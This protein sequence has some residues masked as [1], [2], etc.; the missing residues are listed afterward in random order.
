MMRSLYTLLALSIVLVISSCSSTSDPSVL[1]PTDKRD[2]TIQSNGAT[3]SE[4]ELTG[5]YTLCDGTVVDY[6]IKLKTVTKT[7]VKKDGSNYANYSQVIHGTATDADGNEYNVQQNVTVHTE[8]TECVQTSTQVVNLRFIQK[9]TG[10]V[11]NL[12]AVI[13]VTIDF[14]NDTIDYHLE[15]IE[16]PCD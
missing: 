6:A 10:K 3:V 13:K 7:G 11:F 5:T 14:C 2:A 16:A 9:G 12:R 8:S 1:E 15:K 4:D